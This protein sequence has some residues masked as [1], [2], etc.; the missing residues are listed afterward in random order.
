MLT[1]EGP[2]ARFGDTAA[3]AGIL[4]LLRSNSYLARLPSPIQTVFASF[5]LVMARNRG[6][7][8]TNAEL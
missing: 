5:W 4:A 3:N 8:H 1:S 6:Y 2:V 7:H